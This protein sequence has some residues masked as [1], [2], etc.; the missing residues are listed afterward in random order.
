MGEGEILKWIQGASTP[1]L[2]L[3]IFGAYKFLG[4]LHAIDRR[5][6]QL[7]IKLGVKLDEK[8]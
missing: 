5:L 2:G 7:E 8:I 1:L 6:L 3:L 4:A